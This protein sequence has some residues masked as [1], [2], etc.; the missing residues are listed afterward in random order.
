MRAFLVALFYAGAAGYRAPAARPRRGPRPLTMV[1][2]RA[3]PDVSDKTGFV[4]LPGLRV[5]G[6][7]GVNQMKLESDYLRHPLVEDLADMETIS[8]SH[9]SYNLLKFHGSYQQDDREKR[10]KGAE[11]AWQFMLRLK[12]P[13]GECPGPLYLVLDDLCERFG[14]RGCK[15]LATNCLRLTRL[16]LTGCAGLTDE[17][18]NEFSTVRW[19][20]P[21]LRHLLLAHCRGVGDIGLAWLVEGS[22]SN[23]IVTLNLT[24]CSCTS[25][26]LKSSRDYFP[27]SEMKR[28]P[29]FFGFWPKPRWEHRL[30][31]QAFGR[32]RRGIVK[33]QASYR[34]YCGRR[35]T[36]GLRAWKA[37]EKAT[38]V[39]QKRWRGSKGRARYRYFRAKFIRETHAATVIESG[40]RGSFARGK[41]RRLRKVDQWRRACRAAILV[42]AAYRSLVAR[43]Y[44]TLRLKE[45][46]ILREKRLGAS[47]EIQR[48]YRGLR[49]R[50]RFRFFEAERQRKLM[51]RFRA[52]QKI[53]MWRRCL[54]AKWR[55]DLLREHFERRQALERATAIHIQAKIRTFCTR[56]VYRIMRRKYDARMRIALFCQCAC[57]LRKS[58]IVVWSMPY[59][60]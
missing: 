33:T 8:I 54:L 16:D 40:V 58:Q 48:I 5:Q 36:K 4:G 18:V 37:L 7:D 46:Q 55:T 6:L 3:R 56:R 30:Q 2:E 14:Q 59:I 53:Q 13:S 35:Y 50:Q 22:G 45:A 43:R 49:G 31:I 60:E 9:D 57:R 38:L 25:A 34:G 52:C 11:K 29:G 1:L 10:K 44:A 21:G 24:K 51:R 47:I 32:D 15:A 28:D 42:Q 17:A 26:A 23:D 41:A 20:P 27:H 12:V 39:L 19:K